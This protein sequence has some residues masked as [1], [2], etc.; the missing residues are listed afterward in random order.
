M[1]SIHLSYPKATLEEYGYKNHVILKTLWRILKALLVA[2][3]VF[4]LY[5]SIVLIAI[6]SFNSSA[7]TTEFTGF[8]FQNYVDMFS[9]RS[10]TN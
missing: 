10:L 3:S 6:Q 4:M 9:K 2:F 8:T 1:N 5:I 7:S